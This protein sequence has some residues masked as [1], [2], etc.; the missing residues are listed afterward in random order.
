MNKFILHFVIQIIP[1]I[2]LY[3]F[4]IRFFFSHAQANASSI[5]RRNCPG[6]E[7]GHPAASNS[8][9]RSYTAIASSMSTSFSSSVT[10]ILNNAIMLGFSSTERLWCNNASVVLP[11]LAYRLA[12]NNRLITRLEHC[13]LRERKIRKSAALLPYLIGHQEFPSTPVTSCSNPALVLICL[14]LY[15]L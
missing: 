12:Y 14:F 9:A 4:Y 2:S 7:V 5:I 11:I 13:E 6:G 8:N 3:L 15:R 10:P 1:S